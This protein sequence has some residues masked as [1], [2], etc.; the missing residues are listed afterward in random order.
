MFQARASVQGGPAAAAKAK[1]VQPTRQVTT[2]PKS[3]TVRTDPAFSDS[4]VWKILVR[5]EPGDI[6]RQALRASCVIQRNHLVH[7]G[8]QGVEY[9]PKSLTSAL[10]FDK[11]FSRFAPV[12][13]DLGCGDGA[14][15][16]ALA[17]ENPAHNFLGIERLLGRVRNVCRKVARLDLKNARILRMES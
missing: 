3:A 6:W 12:E 13:I 7:D 5:L 16:A 4:Q 11:V 10:E 15:L 8:E 2:S 14:F 9:V 17:Q 1:T